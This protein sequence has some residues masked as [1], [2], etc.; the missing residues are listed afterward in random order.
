M[1]FTPAMPALIIRTI[2]WLHD[3]TSAGEGMGL[4]VGGKRSRGTIVPEPKWKRGPVL[5][6]SP[7]TA[8]RRELS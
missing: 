5:A 6:D 4:F 2:S 1:R 3:D 8:L 7:K